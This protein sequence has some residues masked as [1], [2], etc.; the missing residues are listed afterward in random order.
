[1][2]LEARER[3]AIIR[4]LGDVIVLMPPLSISQADLRR[5]LEITAESIRAAVCSP[6]R[7]QDGERSLAQ[8]A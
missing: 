1:V 2:V 6:H 7:L 3:G 8:A 5:L 4:P